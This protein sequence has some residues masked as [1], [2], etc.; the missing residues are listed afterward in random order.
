MDN[1]LAKIR[2]VLVFKHDILIV[3]KENKKEQLDKVREIR[4]LLDVAES[5]MMA[6]KCELP[7]SNM[8]GYALK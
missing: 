8:S 2:E 3:T 4:Q 5:Y 6:G 7:K 1:V